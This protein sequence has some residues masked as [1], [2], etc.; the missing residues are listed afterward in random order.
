MVECDCT[1]FSLVLRTGRNDINSGVRRNLSPQ[2]MIKSSS[3]YLQKDLKEK[4][5][6]YGK[7]IHRIWKQIL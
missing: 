7:N 6:C 3:P 4:N 5:K 2:S 1:I